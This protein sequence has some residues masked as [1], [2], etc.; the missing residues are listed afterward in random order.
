MSVPQKFRRIAVY[1][2]AFIGGMWL[3]DRW[4]AARSNADESAATAPASR[5][6]TTRPV[7]SADVQAVVDRLAATY[8]K[9]PISLEA[10]LNGD[11]DVA[12]IVEKKRYLITGSARSA[13]EYRHESKDQVIVTGQ[14]SKVQIY[15]VKR[16]QYATAATDAK[17][18]ESAATVRFFAGDVLLEQN[19]ALFIA[20]GNDPTDVVSYQGQGVQLLEPT[21][22]EGRSFDRLESHKDGT[23]YQTWID[24]ERGTVDRVVIDFTKTLEAKGATQI[25]SANVVIRYTKIEQ[26]GT[27]PSDDLFAFTPPAD[28]TP[29]R[30]TQP[31]ASTGDLAALEG[32]PAPTFELK[33][34]D[35]NVVK[36]SDLKGSVVVLDFWATWCPPCRTGMPVIARAAAKHA[37]KGVKVY[38]VNQAEDAA[39][40]KGFLDEQKLKVATLLD[41]DQSVAMKYGVRAIP[42]TLV[43]GPDGVVRK[44]LNVTSPEHGEGLDEAIEAALR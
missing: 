25:K 19:P 14:P 6:A 9:L 23:S 2:I 17:D 37:D 3:C 27:P 28:A 18:D 32:K 11:F 44:T 29:L 10:E 5:P 16:N 1:A 26:G 40:V 33:D 4:M 24:R 42:A 34:L 7:L 35:G 31:G 20:I 13:N 41:V 22:L 38:A 43:I 39:T 30:L 21:T 8:A 36:L 12:G 15:D